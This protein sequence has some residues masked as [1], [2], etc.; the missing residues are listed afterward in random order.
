MKE[1]LSLTNRQ[2]KVANALLGKYVK[3]LEFMG[4]PTLNAVSVRKTMTTGTTSVIDF[5]VDEKGHLHISVTNE[6]S[7]LFMKP[8]TN[9][10]FDIVLNM[11]EPKLS[12]VKMPQSRKVIKWLDKEVDKDGH[13]NL[14]AILQDYI[15]FEFTKTFLGFAL[16]KKVVNGQIEVRPVDDFEKV[17]EDGLVANLIAYRKAHITD[18]WDVVSVT[19][20]QVEK[21]VKTL[22]ETHIKLEHENTALPK[23]CLSLYSNHLDTTQY[24]FFERKGTL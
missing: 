7:V 17:V 9:E 11:N 1:V 20:V 16:T 22:T 21:V 2:I 14:Q 5:F 12:V 8:V 13:T 19:E 3:Q 24:W 15:P 23:F 18:G 10:D 4:Y 6:K